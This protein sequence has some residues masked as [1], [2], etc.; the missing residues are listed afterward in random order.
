[1]T[2]KFIL[3]CIVGLGLFSAFGCGEFLKPKT[4]PNESI[5]VEA[6]LDCVKELKPNIVEVFNSKLSDQKITDSFAC[7]DLTLTKF[8]EKFRGHVSDEEFSNQEV[9]SLLNFFFKDL[10]ITQEMTDHL[11]LFKYALVGG[12]EKS[13]S[14]TDVETLKTIL[15][16]L[17]KEFINLSPH[18][19]I[20]HGQAKQYTEKEI[21]IGYEQLRTSMSQVIKQ[22]TLSRS[23]YSVHDLFGLLKSFNFDLGRFAGHEE[24]LV[25]IV[26]FIAGHFDAITGDAY[27]EISQSL[28][29]LLEVRALVA[30][31]HLQVDV[32]LAA[33]KSKSL[34]KLLLR[35]VK[36]LKNTPAIQ[37]Q[38]KMDLSKLNLLFPL[39][40]HQGDFRMEISFDFIKMAK[41]LI[42]GGEDHIMTKQELESFEKRISPLLL[43]ASQVVAKVEGLKAMS[44][45]ISEESLGGLNDLLVDVFDVIYYDNA[46]AKIGGAPGVFSKI[47]SLIGSIE[48]ENKNLFLALFDELFSPLGFESEERVL[49]TTNQTIRMIS[50]WNRV[51]ESGSS[52]KPAEIVNLLTTINVHLKI[53]QKKSI[54]A[55]NILKQVKFSQKSIETIKKV[56]VLLFPRIDFAH[57]DIKTLDRMTAMFQQVSILVEKSASPFSLESLMK[58]EPNDILSVLKL[59]DFFGN[60]DSSHQIIEQL[61]EVLVVTQPNLNKRY[62]EVLKTLIADR[63]IRQDA[64]FISI[65]STLRGSLLLSQKL[66]ESKNFDLNQIK[67]LLEFLETSDQMKAKGEVDLKRILTLLES[68]LS[69][70][71][72]KISQI[73]SVYKTFL[74]AD[75]QKLT[76]REIQSAR[77][78]IGLMNTIS[79]FSKHHQN[80]LDFKSL[81]AKSFQ[82]MVD[83]VKTITTTVRRLPLMLQK[84]D[85]GKQGIKID[86]IVKTLGPIHKV[87]LNIPDW[88]YRLKVILVGGES[89]VLTTD[90]V[91]KFLSLLDLL[92][93][94]VEGLFESLK[95]LFSNEPAAI[96][97]IQS[98]SLQLKNVLNKILP[99]TNVAGSRLSFN[100]FEEKVLS[101]VFTKIFGQ[102][103]EDSYERNLELIESVHY[104]LTGD[105]EFTTIQDAMA[106]A[107]SYVDVLKIYRLSSSGHMKVEMTSRNQLVSTIISVQEVLNLVMQS[108]SMQKSNRVSLKELD[109]IVRALI[110]QKLFPVVV[111]SEVFIEFYRTMLARVFVKANDPDF[112]SGYLS[113]ESFLQIQSEMELTK[114]IAIALDKGFVGINEG[115]QAVNQKQ[116]DQ[117]SET[118]RAR[119][120]NSLQEQAAAWNASTNPQ[121]QKQARYLFL[122]IDN[123]TNRPAVHFSNGYI[124]SRN[125]LEFKSTWIGHFRGFYVRSLARLL[126]RGWGDV[127][128]GSIDGRGLSKWYSDFRSYGVAIK[129]FDPRTGNGGERSLLEANLFTV[130]GDGNSEM[131]YREAVE[132]IAMLTTGGGIQFQ[133]LWTW[134]EQNQCVSDVD[135]P[136]GLKYVAEE[137]ALDVLVANHHNLFSNLNG[138]NG[139]GSF[140]RSRNIPP[141]QKN[142]FRGVL[143]AARTDQSKKGEWVESADLRT[144]IMLITYVESLFTALDIDQSGE[145]TVE[146]LRAGYPRFE[147]FVYGFAK[148]TKADALNDSTRDF[149]KVEAGGR[150]WDVRKWDIHWKGLLTR[151]CRPSDQTQEQLERKLAQDMFIYLLLNGQ[152]KID[153]G[154]FVYNCN[155]GDNPI[156]L[157]GTVDRSEMINTFKVLKSVLASKP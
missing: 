29:D 84:L 44:G 88:A 66:T 91:D 147:S 13:L 69:S 138:Y 97:P 107:A 151:A 38:S 54:S 101:K 31:R 113:R 111:S 89:M 36:I 3:K 115:K 154:D 18:F 62:L 68:E 149:I 40:F 130:S 122:T 53:Q 105:E 1:M 106:L 119:I 30:N 143:D 72:L 129:S 28:V 45:P 153:A 94:E 100:E 121:S 20:F 60:T 12:S 155:F 125:Y 120:L 96:V 116:A 148:T 92:A 150:W 64:D 71:G 50:A 109:H 156:K 46:V 83:Q 112:S 58:W 24:K 25:S 77:H 5:R 99:K 47:R 126:I 16:E 90:E 157:E 152:L 56:A 104:F 78:Y 139:F 43:V 26:E 95:I 10:K 8:Q 98:A 75:I 4:A 135:D 14:K 41:V 51:L 136:F 132:Y 85:S 61:F 11:I 63:L 27:A 142:F 141:G 52:V 34:E 110:S 118:I 128:K 49:Q 23:G 137:C 21:Q 127:K 15:V 17:K 146:E 32:D 6:K 81:D 9:K 76:P 65:L 108:P 7:V 55:D 42:L 79:S 48:H 70:A 114:A 140:M 59:S 117:E 145:L 19:I 123:F 80:K 103:Q 131:S 73:Q 144:V 67:N 87:D 133:K 134:L 74:G 39:S 35:M 22:S 124:L 102:N 93:P 57:F 37:A 86:E 2:S 33:I 82:H